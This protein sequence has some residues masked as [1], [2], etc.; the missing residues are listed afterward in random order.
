MV[1]GPHLWCKMPLRKVKRTV[2]CSYSLHRMPNLVP[3]RYLQVRDRTCSG[4]ENRT[5]P[6]DKRTIALGM[7]MRAVAIIL[8]ISQT[9]TGC[10]QI[11]QEISIS[12]LSPRSTRK[13]AHTSQSKQ[14]LCVAE[15]CFNLLTL[16]DQ[17]A[18]RTTHIHNF[19]EPHQ[20]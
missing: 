1:T 12:A 17:G 9:S 3:T 2:N 14:S 4:W 18:H 15:N 10:A 6:A 5:R 20:V 19:S 8:T 16:K 7:T 13:K 11:L